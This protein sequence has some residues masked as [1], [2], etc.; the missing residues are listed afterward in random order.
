MPWSSPTRP[1]GTRRP[2]DG[3]PPAW[4]LG[5]SSRSEPPSFPGRDPVRPA[6]ALQ[7]AADVYAQAGITDP[8]QQI[9]MAELYVPFSWHEPIWLEA[10]G[11]ADEGD[12]WKLVDDGTTELGGSLPVNA[13]GGVLSSNP[14]GASGLLR[15]AEAANQVRGAAGEHQVDGAE[16]AIGMA[17]GA[18]NQYFSTWAVGSS[19]HP[20]E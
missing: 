1:A 5:S 13:S 16:V 11:L 10:F 14:I 4:I 2:A 8:R 15:F 18:N 12:G 20:F 9:D 7:C 3:R 17:Y 6:A 19:L